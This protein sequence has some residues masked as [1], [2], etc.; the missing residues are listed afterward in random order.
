M[1][2]AI[3]STTPVHV[4][5]MPECHSA[6]MFCQLKFQRRKHKVQHVRDITTSLLD[7]PFSY[8]LPLTR[9]DCCRKNYKKNRCMKYCQCSDKTNSW[10]QQA[11]KS[12]TRRSEGAILK[13]TTDPLHLILSPTSQSTRCFLARWQVDGEQFNFS[14]SGMVWH[15]TRG[16]YPHN[17][18]VRGLSRTT[19][20]A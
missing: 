19:L 9:N 17:Y 15:G 2:V 4:M 1:S 3:T 8:P 10:V 16:T 5:T 7:L 12:P 14:I 20:F 11:G 13:G 6:S 18:K